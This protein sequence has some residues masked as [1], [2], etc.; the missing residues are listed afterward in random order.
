MAVMEVITMRKAWIGIAVV[1]ALVLASVGIVRAGVYPSRSLEL[2]RQN[3]GL[4]LKHDTIR[5]DFFPMRSWGPSSGP[6]IFATGGIAVTLSVTISGGPAEFRVV[7]EVGSKFE[8]R[9][10]RPGTVRFEPGSGKES[11]SFTFV[12]GA[13]GEGRNVNLFWRSPTGAPVTMHGGS[14]VIQYAAAS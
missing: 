10:M 8:E 12:T 4:I 6:R 1:A 11:F 5:T 9:T 13:G 14:V 2:D 3:I 7:Q